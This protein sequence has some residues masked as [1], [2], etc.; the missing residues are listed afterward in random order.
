MDLVPVRR[1]YRDRGSDAGYTAG[2]GWMP[3]VKVVLRDRGLHGDRPVYPGVGVPTP[4]LY[5]D[6]GRVNTSLDTG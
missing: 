2:T 5:S 6:L 3:V 1:R 4:Y